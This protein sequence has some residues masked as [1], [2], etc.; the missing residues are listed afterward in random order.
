MKFAA[1]V[2]VATV[3]GLK[4]NAQEGSAHQAEAISHEKTEALEKLK[5]WEAEVDQAVAHQHELNK[6]DFDWGGL[7]NKGKATYGALKNIW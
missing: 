2:L 6:E 3:A 4:L 7:L 5:A 1:I